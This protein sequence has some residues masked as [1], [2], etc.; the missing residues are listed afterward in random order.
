MTNSLD[1]NQANNHHVIR[2]DL[3]QNSSAFTYIKY[4]VDLDQLP[5]IVAKEA[6]KLYLD[7]IC[8]KTLR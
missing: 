2:R 1:S 8:H 4:S 6:N 5:H 7:S 3:N